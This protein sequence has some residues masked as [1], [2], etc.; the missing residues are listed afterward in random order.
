MIL[1]IHD[2]GSSKSLWLSH[3]RKI[4]S[5]NMTISNR[6]LLDMFTISLPGH[7]TNDKV[8]L[9]MENLL[10]KV[11][12]FVTNKLEIQSTL[13]DNMIFS[14]GYSNFI[15]L[16]RDEKLTIFGHGFGG[17]V[18]LEY[19]M[20]KPQN[21]TQIV[22]ISCGAFF[23]KRALKGKLRKISIL[24]RR[25]RN[26]LSRL[27]GTTKD[28]YKKTAANLLIENQN[29]DLFSSGYDIMMDFSFSKSF[30][31]LDLDRQKKVLSIPILTINS[32]FQIVSSVHSAKKLRYILDPYSAIFQTKNTLV[33]THKNRVNYVKNIVY[34]WTNR[35]P[36]EKHQKQFIKDVRLFLSE[37][38]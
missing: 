9:T 12:K 37:N 5:L 20:N 8:E 18:A 7:Y 25:S 30:S 36:H 26:F 19:A 6:E 3:I 13:A 34:G 1:F 27:I 17:M 14:K 32:M 31:K 22:S 24:S 2:L 33:F 16:L 15:K 10:V 23:S 29:Y 21:I 4:F 11:D 38:V 28:V 35:H